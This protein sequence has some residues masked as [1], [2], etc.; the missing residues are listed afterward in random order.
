MT[1]TKAYAAQSATSP[2]A[3][4]II[5]RREP[6]P[7]DVKID[8]AYCGVCHSDLHTAR[9]EWAGTH[10]PCVPGHE[11]VGTVVAVGSHVTKFKVGDRVG[12]GC[13]VDSCRECESCRAGNEQYCYNGNVG[14]YN[15]KDVHLG[16]HTFGGYS[17]GSTPPRRFCAPASPSIRRSA[18]G[19]PAPARKSA[20][21]GWAASVTWASSSP[22]PWARMW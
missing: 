20:S 2:L 4:H 13:M 15:G 14:T 17:A 7:H 9:G 1:A 12:V 18:T 19:A 22:A 5:E 8:I 11:I 16:G 10:Y 3:P 6:G 21:S